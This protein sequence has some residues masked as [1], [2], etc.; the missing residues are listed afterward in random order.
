[1]VEHGVSEANAF[2]LVEF[3]DAKECSIFSRLPRGRI[4]LIAFGS[5]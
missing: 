1:M 3:E 2:T 4:L 5:A